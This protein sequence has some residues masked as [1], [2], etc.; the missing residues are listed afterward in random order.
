MCEV[1]QIEAVDVAILLLSE[2]DRSAF[3]IEHMASAPAL[4]VNKP[5]LLAEPPVQ[6]PRLDID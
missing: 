2:L 5:Y 3:N 1:G 6:D 4:A